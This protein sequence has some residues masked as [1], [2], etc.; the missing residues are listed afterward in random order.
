MKHFGAVFKL[1]LR[2]ESRTQVQEEEAVASS[3][4][5]CFILATPMHRDSSI[6]ANR[7]TR[8]YENNAETLLGVIW[9]DTPYRT[10]ARN[11]YT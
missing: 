5:S 6:R 2:E 1:D 11:E 9:G 4:S 7:K 3:K 8:G 10:A